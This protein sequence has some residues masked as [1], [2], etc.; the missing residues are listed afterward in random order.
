MPTI[1][2]SRQDIETRRYP[3]VIDRERVDALTDE[4]I[5]RQIARDPDL[6]PELTEADFARARTKP[7]LIRS[8]IAAEETG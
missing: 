2:R 6:A 7:P 8:K 3:G 4:D 5:R 1:V